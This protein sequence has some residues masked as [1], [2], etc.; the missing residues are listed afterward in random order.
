MDD[1]GGQLS[2]EASFSDDVS[3]VCLVAAGG[4]GHLVRDSGELLELGEVGT[5]CSLGLLGELDGVDDSIW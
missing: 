4:E 1:L 2:H 5:L 3:Q